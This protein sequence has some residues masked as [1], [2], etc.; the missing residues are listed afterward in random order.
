MKPIIWRARS[1]ILLLF[2]THAI[3]T[4]GGCAEAAWLAYAIGAPT[5]PNRK[6][7]SPHD[8]DT[9]VRRLSS[10]DRGVRRLAA[11]NFDGELN[12]FIWTQHL[13]GLVAAL[14]H[15]LPPDAASED[16]RVQHVAL[17]ALASLHEKARPALDLLLALRRESRAAS[18]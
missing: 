16:V 13:P 4:L 10:T 14:R 7:L 2:A 17:L 15:P 18:Y 3:G 1:P 5:T 9:W 11:V 8:V 12:H 6:P